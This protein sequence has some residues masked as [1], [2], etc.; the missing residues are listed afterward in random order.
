MDGSRRPADR[1]GSGARADGRSDD[2]PRPGSQAAHALPR[3][4]GA[5]GGGA[6]D[7]PAAP[8]DSLTRDPGGGGRAAW[9]CEAIRTLGDPQTLDL[10]RVPQEPLAEL[11]S[12]PFPGERWVA[13]DHPLVA[14]ERQRDAVRAA[15]APDLA[16]SV[17][18]GTRR[19]QTP[20][21]PAELGQQGG[22]GRPHDPL[23]QPCTG[24]RAEP[25]WS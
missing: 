15:T 12:P 3:G 16:A 11:P 25:G 18:A 5:W 19:T 4:A 6:R 13:W 22:Q 2:E 20:V 14:P 23:A 17:R 24:Q 10:A 1:G 8:R 7:T 9:R 21:A